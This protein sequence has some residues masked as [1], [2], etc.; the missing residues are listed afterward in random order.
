ML[1]SKEIIV[2]WTCYVFC[3][4]FHSLKLPHFNLYW[5][6]IEFWG[7]IELEVNL[8]KLSQQYSNS[9]VKLMLEYLFVLMGNLD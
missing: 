3:G 7:N 2:S 9:V 1:I 5:L 8:S 6:K 4:S